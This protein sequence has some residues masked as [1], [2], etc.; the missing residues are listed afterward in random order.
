L[1]L[2]G[3]IL[4]GTT[5][6]TLFAMNTDGT[7][8]TNLARFTAPSRGYP[9]GP[10]LLSGDRI[11][12]STSS[13]TTAGKGIVYSVRTNGTGFVVLHQFTQTLDPDTTNSDGALPR[14]LCRLGNALYGTTEIGGPLGCGVVFRLSFPPPVLAMVPDGASV[15]LQWPASPG[16]FNL[17]TTTN[18]ASPADWADHPVVPS[19]VNGQNIVTNPAADTQKFFRLKLQ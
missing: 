10:F 12:G 2:S 9:Y 3:N 11:Y 6:E 4:Y 19:I 1:I 13:F 17:Q 15:L 16:G 18:L 5:S 8:F 7:G 14:G